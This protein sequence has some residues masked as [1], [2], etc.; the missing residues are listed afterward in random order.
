MDTSFIMRTTILFDID[1]TLF[2]SDKYR[3]IC[4]RVLG[5]RL[6][7]KDRE[8]FMAFAEQEY[9]KVRLRGTFK[10]GEFI[11][12]LITQLGISGD[13]DD[14]SEIFFDEQYIDEACYPEVTEVLQTLSS[15]VTTK[16]GI[17][18]F[19]VD[20]LQRKKIQSIVHILHSDAIYINEVDKLEDIPT[21]LGKHAGEQLYIIDDVLNVLQRFKSL[22][23]SVI[24]V[25][26]ERGRDRPREESKGSFNPDFKIN[27][28]SELLPIIK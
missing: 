15:N 18:S 5:E 14:L 9:R 19:G 1:H 17:L 21:I 28:L 20:S 8:A 13:S 22:D 3:E 26:I 27:E 10:P 16:L 25:L 12:Q 23:P 7:Q 4:F 2:D 24:T 11:Y 6:K